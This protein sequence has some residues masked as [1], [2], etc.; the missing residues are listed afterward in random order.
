MSGV[1]AGAVALSIRDLHKSFRAKEEK[2]QALAGV[3][4]EVREG[5]L[6]T[7]L[8]PSGC[9][10]TTTLRCIAGFEKPTSGRIEFQGQDFTAVPPFRRGI[11]MVFQSYAL[12]PHLSVF[13][14]VA[15]GLKA[16]RRPQEEIRRKV[17]ELLALVG[18]ES[19]AR[20]K[21]GELSGGQQQRIALARA[22]VYDPRLLLLD[23]PLSNLDAKLRIY[24]REEIR[25]IQQQARVTAI[26][27]THD[28]EEALSISDRI[29]VMHAG[30][31]SQIG[32]PDDIYENPGSVRVA[33]FIGQANFLP[34]RVLRR[35]GGALLRFPSGE[36]TPLRAG[37]PLPANLANPAEGESILFARPEHL[38]IAGP[39]GPAHGPQSAQG[40]R[41]RVRTILYLGTQVRYFVEVFAADSAREVLVDE[42]RRIPGVREG[43]EVAVGFQWD[44][45]RLFPPE[46][47]DQ[48]AR[49]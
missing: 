34:C 20:R 43:S 25:R 10:K 42:E 37:V 31:V 19:T 49:E 8:G 14:N 41:G 44:S 1:S 33:D 17:G 35:D 48:L 5:E 36:E 11:G 30:R 24:M 29:A 15:Y 4:L 18:L 23:E 9:G 27:V 2:V 46:Q 21:P 47:R 45:V 40:L 39:A 3:S 13:E 12:F 26:Y 22:L 38:H 28:Q 16:R 7:L 6:F 32:A